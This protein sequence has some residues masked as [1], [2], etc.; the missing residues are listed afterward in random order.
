VSVLLAGQPE[1]TGG[2]SAQNIHCVSHPDRFL[3]SFCSHLI[4]TVD[5]YQELQRPILS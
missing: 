2:D 5:L 4:H 3:I 1:T